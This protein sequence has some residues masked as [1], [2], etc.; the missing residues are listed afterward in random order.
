[1][2]HFNRRANMPLIAFQAMTMLIGFFISFST[3][4]LMDFFDTPQRR[5][6]R[7][8]FIYARQPPASATAEENFSADFYIYALIATAS[9]QVMQS[10]DSDYIT[11]RFIGHYE[12]AISFRRPMSCIKLTGHAMPPRPCH[13]LKAAFCR[14]ATHFLGRRAFYIHVRPA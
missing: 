3:G 4:Q 12:S 8:L 13:A 1:M 2:L 5:A 14:H 10:A 6:A 9:S 11:M 7:G